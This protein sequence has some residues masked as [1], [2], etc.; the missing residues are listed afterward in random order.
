MYDVIGSAAAGC[1]VVC[2]CSLVFS[3][4]SWVDTWERGRTLTT[5]EP[6]LPGEKRH[7]DELVWMTV[8]MNLAAVVAGAGA[9]V[10]A[11]LLITD[12]RLTPTGVGVGWV[13]AGIWLVAVVSGIG[14]FRLRRPWHRWIDDAGTLREY[15]RRGVGDRKLRPDEL[16]VAQERLRMLTNKHLRG[17]RSRLLG[18]LGLHRPLAAREWRS[19]WPSAAREVSTTFRRVD[20]IRYGAVS[21]WSAVYLA[22]AVL[23]TVFLVIGAL[24]G[25]VVL[26]ELAVA[27]IFAGGL[28]VCG[29]LPFWSARRRLV[30]ETRVLA[31]HRVDL[32]EVRR[33]LTVLLRPPE[34]VPEPPRVLLQLGSWALVRQ[35]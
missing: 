30:L 8:L 2:L 28:A 18:R 22:F 21:G 32:A 25:P 16:A 27:G 1:L 26:T 14:M 10:G 7:L 15:L 24:I 17:R 23:S 34:P 33:H 19:S 13:Y 20:V 35:R 29:L 4:L 11:S 12:G 6:G 9:G 5:E 31:R 3:A